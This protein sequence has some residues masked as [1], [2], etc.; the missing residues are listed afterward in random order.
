MK[1]L[2]MAQSLTGG[3]AER[4]A[5]LW[6]RGFVEQQHKVGLV[7][8]HRPNSKETYPIPDG[9]AR[10]YIGNWLAHKLHRRC[11]IDTY[12][13]R[14]LRE[15]VLDFR[16]DL[17]IGVLHPWAEWARKATKGMGILIINTE[18]NAFE[19]PADFPLSKR[20]RRRKYVW[21]K[22]Y[23]HVTVLNEADKACV[24]GVLLNVSVLPNPLAFQP[25]S[26]IPEKQNIILAAGRL[27]V[28]ASKGF[29][30]LIAAWG[31]VAP[32]HKEWCLQIAGTGKEKDKEAIMEMIEYAGVLRQTTLLG[33]VEDMLPIYQRSAVFALSSRYEGFGMVL[34]EAMS[35]GCACVACDYKGRQK[36]IITNDNEGI[37]CPTEDVESLANA[38][39]RLITD[40][41]FRQ[42]LQQGAISRSHYYSLDNTMKRWDTILSE[43]VLVK[44]RPLGGG[45]IVRQSVV[46]HFSQANK[47]WL[48]RR[49]CA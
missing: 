48:V 35:Q 20:E 28:W 22:R 39:E 5:S 19:R 4:V 23:D 26:L 10:Y 14:K 18:H 15:I 40:E 41:T 42:K 3:G 7:M 9:V 43:K 2:V 45:K 38:L 12:F 47:L 25:A 16:P 34:I 24:E 37:I 6:I 44:N 21:N 17:I 33:Y 49:R 8:Y 27:S 1:I 13:V 32:K 11:Y 30:I 36:E 46:P 31:Q 29:D